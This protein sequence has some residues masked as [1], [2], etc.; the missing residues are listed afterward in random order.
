MLKELRQEKGWTQ[1]ELA[2][3]LNVTYGSINGWENR[4]RQP[5]F[6]MVYEIA[7]IFEVTV[8]QLLGVEEY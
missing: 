1:K 7:K 3:K 4:G 5:S 6:E 8:G 2:K